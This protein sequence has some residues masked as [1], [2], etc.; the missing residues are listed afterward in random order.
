MIKRMNWRVAWELMKAIDFI[1]PEDEKINKEMIFAKI[2]TAVNNFFSFTDY[3]NG[4]N[5]PQ[6][7]KENDVKFIKI[8]FSSNQDYEDVL[9]KINYIIK[10]RIEEKTGISYRIPL[11]PLR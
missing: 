7:I 1:C 11:I 10:Y 8:V 4:V 9:T 6:Y 2:S 3:I 5:V